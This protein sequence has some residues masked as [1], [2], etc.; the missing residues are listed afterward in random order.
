MSHSFILQSSALELQNHLVDGSFTSVALTEKFLDQIERHNQQ[1]LDLKA[2]ISVAPRA[3]VLER[4]RNLDKERST[5]T[6]R[7]K[8]HGIPIVIKVP[9]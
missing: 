3:N 9:H 4:A 5:G 7:S 1:G 2:I 6:L 8:L